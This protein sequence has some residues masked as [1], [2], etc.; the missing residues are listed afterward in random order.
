ML[1]LFKDFFGLGVGFILCR[2]DTAS[3]VALFEQR[4]KDRHLLLK[5]FGSSPIF[6]SFF[7]FPFIVFLLSSFLPRTQRRLLFEIMFSYPI[8]RIRTPIHPSVWFSIFT[9][10]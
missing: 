3:Y 8:R 2:V 7:F 5:L 1:Y 4:R 6:F 9:L 10:P